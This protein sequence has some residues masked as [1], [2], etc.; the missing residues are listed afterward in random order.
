MVVDRLVARLGSRSML[1]LTYH[2]IRPDEVLPPSVNLQGKHVSQSA[3]AEQIDWLSLAGYRFLDGGELHWM[4]RRRRPARG[5]AV[6]ITFDDGYANN[7]TA[8][9]P[10]LHDR[11]IRA[12]IFL[13]G[14]FIARRKPLW[15]DRLEQAFVRA[16]ADE[17]VVDIDNRKR[18]LQLRNLAERRLAEA[19]T[20]AMCKRLS[21]S[22]RERVLDS[23]ISR[24]AAPS[25]P[26]PILYH[27][28]SWTQIDELQQA[29]W[30]IGTHT[31]THTILAGLDAQDVRQEVGHAKTIFEDRL[32]VVCDLFAY[33]NGLRGDFTPATQRLLS[34]MGKV[35][36]FAS[37][38]GRVKGG[39]DP[40]AMRRVAVHDRMGI[41]EFRLRTTGALGAAK[42]VKAGMRRAWAAVSN[43]SA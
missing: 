18:P 12:S 8:A 42:N 7:F 6:A 27:P 36:A 43:R 40:F 1:I 39:F 26:L 25:T 4:I 3:F 24:L 35:C 28:L 13:V 34:E 29:G 33:P 22:D 20:R 10:I 19:S 41:G 11:S 23:L 16:T 38:E 30:E 2:G 32:G 31:M 5:P 14:E 15:V 9:L 37:I 21:S 17:I